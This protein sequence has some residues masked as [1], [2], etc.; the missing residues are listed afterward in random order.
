[1]TI[2]EAILA[3]RVAKKDI[4]GDK[5]LILSLTNSRLCDTEVDDIAIINDHRKGIGESQYVEIRV[6][7]PEISPHTGG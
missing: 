7:H 6:E 5:K 1:M 2:D 4:G 3:L